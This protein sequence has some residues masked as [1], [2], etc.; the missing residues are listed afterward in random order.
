MPTFINLYNVI[1][2]KDIIK[3]RYKG[4]LQAFVR[5][6]HEENGS[7]RQEDQETFSV[8][9]MNACDDVILFLV[10]QGLDF[11]FENKRS[12]DFVCVARYGG[13][14]WA[15]D[16]LQHN[17]TYAW[18][19]DCDKEKIAKAE[20]INGMQMSDIEDAFNRGENPWDTIF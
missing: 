13:A 1:I 16:W 8:A 7:R 5:W 19:K 12:D 3:A 11:D 10:E 20:E 4:G 17:A 15:V 9:R 18:H 2:P 14:L 6:F